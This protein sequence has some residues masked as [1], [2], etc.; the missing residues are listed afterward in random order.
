LEEALKENISERIKSCYP[1][2]DVQ[3]E[4]VEVINALASYQLLLM[5]SDDS[6][7]E[8]ERKKLI[9][10]GTSLINDADQI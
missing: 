8:E 1:Q 2:L 6:S 4:K 5:I 9:L 7:S 3:K 10:K